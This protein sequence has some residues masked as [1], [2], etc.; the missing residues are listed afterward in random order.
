MHERRVSNLETGDVIVFGDTDMTVDD[1]E[2]NDDGTYFVSVSYQDSYG[3]NGN[4]WDDIS[5]DT[6][7][8][9]Y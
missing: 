7:Y 3:Y 2:R 9:I 5:P 8:L 6:V 1:I 4:V